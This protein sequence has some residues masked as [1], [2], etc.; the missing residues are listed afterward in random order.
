MMRNSVGVLVCLGLVGGCGPTGSGG[1][2]SGGGPGEVDSSVGPGSV[3]AR[4]N[5][6]DAAA[7]VTESNVAEEATAPVDI[8]WVVDSS[9]SMNDETT[10]VQNALNSFSQFIAGE[11]IDY[12][13]ILIGSA[14]DMSVPPPLGGS[15][16]FMHVNMSIGSSDALE[17]IIQT[18]SSWQSF[19]RPNALVHF[20]VV[21]DD[22]SDINHG[23]FDSMLGALSGPGFPNGYTFHSI[24]SEEVPIVLPPPLPPIPGPCSGG[25]GAGG[26]A[27]PGHTYINMSSSTGGV[28]R[29]ICESNWDPI[30]TAVA[31]AV[32][33]TTSI[34]CTFDI[35]LPPVGE[36]LDP[37]QV[38]VSYDP[39]GGSITIPRVDNQAACGSGQGWYYDNPTTPTQ[40]LM[41]PTTCGDFGG[42]AGQVDIQ[43]G[44]AT[45]VD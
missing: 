24:C 44:C 37:D 19:L 26:A 43:F 36:T 20:V 41:C 42:G 17:K 9:G 7:C 4:T 30:F 11:S 35:P 27:A 39:G 29:S 40:I 13:V 21:T 32:A 25:L 23:Q 28:W 16:E 33:V 22:E 3:D 14:S 2:D 8:I 15:A 45:I 18:Y 34:P 12:R 5:V 38:N 31:Q 1:V 10:A 6:T